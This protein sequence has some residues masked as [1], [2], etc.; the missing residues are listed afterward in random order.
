[1]TAGMGRAAIAA[2]MPFLFVVLWSTGFIGAKLGLPHAEP[3]TFLAL[4]FALVIPLLAVAAV[5]ARAPWPRDPR[6]LAHLGVSGL[7]VHGVYLG[8]VFAAIAHGLPSGVT[9]LIVGLQPVLTAVA[10]SRLLG[11]TIA[12]RQWAG[13]ALGLVGVVLVLWNG[14]AAAMGTSFDWTAPAFAVAALAGITAGTLWQKRHCT[15]MDLRTGSVVQYLAAFALVLPLALAAETM[16]VDWSAEF[17]FAL[18]WLVLVLSVGAVS[19]LMTLIRLG[20]ASRIASVFYLVPPVTA[21]MAW[22]LFGEAL[23]P[24]ALA[25]IAVAATGVALVIRRT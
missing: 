13:L 1:M 3:F 5:M 11:E 18:G 17:V 16:A 21:L 25:G 4:R 19:L 24:L 8:G 7:L 12:P 20:E 6:L 15:A 9:A 23:S 22:A 14:L 10:A 2:A